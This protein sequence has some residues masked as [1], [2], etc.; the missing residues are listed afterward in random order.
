MEAEYQA[1]HEKEEKEEY[2]ANH[3]IKHKVD[4]NYYSG[5]IHYTDKV[6]D[7][8]NNS[9][10]SVRIFSDINAGLSY[11]EAKRKYLVCEMLAG[12]SFDAEMV[13]PGTAMYQGRVRTGNCANK[14]G[15]IRTFD[16]P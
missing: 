14:W 5:N 11:K 12:S 13:V 15:Y 8:W 1:D 6:V 7:L 16:I 3:P 10:V 9:E 2:K 4:N